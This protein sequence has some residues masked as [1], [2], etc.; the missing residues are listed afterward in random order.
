MSAVENQGEVAAKAVVH[1][2]DIANNRHITVHLVPLKCNAGFTRQV[3]DL[4]WCVGSWGQFS[5]R[6]S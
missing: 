5:E 2:K 6:D 3:F 4:Y 1:V